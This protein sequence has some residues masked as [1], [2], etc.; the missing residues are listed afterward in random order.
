[1]RLSACDRLRA[2]GS[3][4]PEHDALLERALDDDIRTAWV[5]ADATSLEALIGIAAGL[6]GGAG[7]VP[8]IRRKIRLAPLKR[9]ALGWRSLI[10]GGP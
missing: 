8:E 6:P 5:V 10:R 7:R 1:V 9:V 2:A 4:G 3:Y